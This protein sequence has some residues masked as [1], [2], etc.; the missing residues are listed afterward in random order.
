MSPPPA[1]D[2]IRTRIWSEEPEADDDFSTRVAYCRGYDVYGELVGQARWVEMLVLLLRGEAP[3]DREAGLLE[4]LAV[5][6]AN[7]GPRHPATHAAM[8]A[9]AGGSTAAAALMAALAVDAGQHAGAREVWQAM[10]RWAACGT[11]R[12]RWEAALAAADPEPPAA[13]W[14]HTAHVAG[15]EPY[16]AQAC[17]AVRQ[18]LG[19]LA[20]LSPGP[21]LPWLRRERESLECAAA[22]GVAFSGVVAAALCDLGFTPDQGEMLYLL[23]RLPG[24]AAHALEQREYGFKDFP[25]FSLELEDDPQGAPA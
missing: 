1:Q 20:E 18:L 17:L 9:G 24:A 21:C 19:V 22:R 2:R 15:F 13:I 3:S 23:L 5:A 10:R 8:C 14:P 12:D 7:A 25:F 4:A 11:Q 16:R 6:L